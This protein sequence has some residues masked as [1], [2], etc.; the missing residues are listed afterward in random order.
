MIKYMKPLQ[1]FGETMKRTYY[2]PSAVFLGLNFTD[3]YASVAMSDDCYFLATLCGIFPR[4]ET[5]LDKLGC[6]LEGIIVGGN[7]SVTP[8]VNIHNFMDDL[9]KKG[10]FESLKYTCWNDNM[11]S[12]EGDVAS[13][14]P[15]P[16][17]LPGKDWLTPRSHWPFE[18][19]TM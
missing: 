10:K 19:N 7:N 3:E 5:L 12:T 13:M 9:C 18:R 11:Q 2:M 15:P 1:L 14:V 16:L 17:V 8:P 6:E 4:D